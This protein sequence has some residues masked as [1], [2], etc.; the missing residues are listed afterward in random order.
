MTEQ[1]QAAQKKK[2]RGASNMLLVRRFNPETDGKEPAENLLLIVARGSTQS[3]L[4]KSSD[5]PG[6][7]GI[8]TL[9]ESFE[10]EPKTVME[11]KRIKG[12]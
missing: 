4:R 11:R 3:D 1:P 5:Q 7:F 12:M 2:T 6:R 9:R 10:Q 8:L